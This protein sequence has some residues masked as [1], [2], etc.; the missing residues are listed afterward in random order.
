MTFKVQRVSPLRVISALMMREM[1]TRFGATRLGYLW[2][3][4]DPAIQVLTFWVLYLVLGRERIYGVPYALFVGVGVLAFILFRQSVERAVSAISSNQGL[5]F[6]RQV[7]PSDTVIARTA[8]EVLI[9]L[10][11]V[12]LGALLAWLFEATWKVADVSLVIIAFGL[13]VLMST[14]AALVTAVVSAYSDS[15][16]KVLQI[17]LRAMYFVSCVFY[18]LSA[19]PQDY[20]GWVAANPVSQAIELIRVGLFSSYVDADTNL[21]YLFACSAGLFLL[22][23][24]LMN[25]QQ[26]ALRFHD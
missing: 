21:P 8:V 17:L 10:A 15:A 25:S 24:A 1:Q 14:G 19:I 23:M 5:F 26:D 22:G 9:V 13:L 11:L 2:A 16:G 7:H 18:P 12:A 4:V 6:Y 3:I 20:R